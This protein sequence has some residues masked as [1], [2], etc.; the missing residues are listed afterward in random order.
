M[1]K[2]KGNRDENAPVL[3]VELP[4]AP[5]VEM[6]FAQTVTVYLSAEQVQTLKRL[7]AGLDIVNARTGDGVPVHIHKSRAIKWLLDRVAEAYGAV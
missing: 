5:Q 1:S 6:T 7:T 3:M 4:E 2:S